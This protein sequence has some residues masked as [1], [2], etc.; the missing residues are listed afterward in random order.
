MR[1]GGAAISGAVVTLAL[2]HFAAV[3]HQDDQADDKGAGQFEGACP[4]Q[5]DE[6]EPAAEDGANQADEVAD[7]NAFE[8]NQV[9]A[10]LLYT[11]P[12]PRDS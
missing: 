11:S 4:H 3:E 5:G 10:C 2:V 8:A 12:S 6:T 1:A 9:N 7:V